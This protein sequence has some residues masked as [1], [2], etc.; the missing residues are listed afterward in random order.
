MQFNWITTSSLEKY[1][2]ITQVYGICFDQNK[3]ILIC[4]QNSQSDWQI[5]GGKP[6]K[7]ESFE[8]TLR[9]EFLEEVQVTIH[10]IRLLGLIHVNKPK[11]TYLFEGKQFFQ[12]RY[13]CTL[14]TI[15]PQTIDPAINST[16]QRKFVT[17]QEIDTYILWGT[18]GKQMFNAAYQQYIVFSHS[19]T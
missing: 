8:E 6:E 10:N 4:R 18:V 14:D 16:W 9:R 11:N 2:P 3:R 1:S 7:N 13:I 12:A 15:F 5:P 17:I 19:N